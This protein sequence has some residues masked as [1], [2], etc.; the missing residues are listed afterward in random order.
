MTVNF[1]PVIEVIDE[2]C[3]NCHA[4]IAACPVKYCI[5]GSGEKVRIRHELCIG[6]GACIEACSHGARVGMDDS[7]PFFEAL[8][9][10]ERLV[11]I[12]APAVAAH[13][14]K[15]FLRLNGW[16]KRS[17]VAAVFDVAFGAELT[18]RSYLEHIKAN[19]PRLVIAQPCPALVS[20]VELYRPELIPYLAPADSP[21]LHA[22]KMIKRFYP[23]YADHKIAVI[24]PC[25]AKRREFD[26]TGYGDY[27]VTIERLVERLERERIR[28]ADYPEADFDNPPAE[29]AVLFSRPGGLKATIEREAPGALASVRKIEGPRSLYPYI[30]SLPEALAKG[31]QP[32]VVDC[33]NCEKGCNGGTG[34]GAMSMGL[35]ILESAVEGRRR[36]QVDRLGGARRWGRGSV[37][38]IRKSVASRW[39]PGLYARG[40]VDRSS[41]SRLGI[42]SKDRLEA[43]YADM[44]KYREEDFLNCAS[45]GYGS[46]ERMAI[47]IFNGLNRSENCHRYQTESIKASKAGLVEMSKRLDEEIA[48]A[49]GYLAELT[50]II[51]ELAEKTTEDFAAVEQSSKT[52]E[53]MMSQMRR[54]SELSKEKGS[55]VE[56]LMEAVGKGE[57]VLKHSLESIR[58]TQA[59]MSGIDGM[60]KQISKI[61]SQ[62]NLLSMNAAIEAAHAGDAGL[63]FAV[64]AEEI[65]NLATQA[66]LSSTEIGKT[67]KTLAGGMGE[68]GRLSEETGSVINGILKEVEETGAGIAEIFRLLDE[69]SSGSVQ[70]EA[71]LASIKQTAAKSWDYYQNMGESLTQVEREVKAIS[72]ISKENLARIS[73]SERADGAPGPMGR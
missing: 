27:N 66:A 21:M 46:C 29:R 15:D 2:K 25:V 50:G 70:I 43:I 51:P 22:M 71:A 63:G 33:L 73:E 55:A 4:C 7:G 18:V 72:R 28:L 3:I 54:S 59:G 24:S 23:A 38:A 56:R 19:K 10:R 40:Y 34:T 1:S 31:V 47:A 20:Y 52:I 57:E 17:G 35:D 49:T 48:K 45:C 39:K 58:G 12:V 53:L 14:P 60:V 65:R 26:E 8:K 32:Q 41:A 16:L 68:A 6:C 9:R 61:S 37:A 36:A 67:L 44:R 42:P 64:V 11:A 13:F 30:D 69:M 5:D 62:T